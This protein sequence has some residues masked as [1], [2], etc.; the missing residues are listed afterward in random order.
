MFH[1]GVAD[2]FGQRRVDRYGA[3]GRKLDKALGEIDIVGGKRRADLALGDIAIEAS[4]QRLVGD[5]DRILGGGLELRARG[6]A[7]ADHDEG[8]GRAQRGGCQ[9]KQ[10]VAQGLDRELTDHFP[11]IG[12][13]RY[14]WPA[15]CR[16]IPVR[17]A[18]NL[19]LFESW[20]RMPCW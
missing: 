4:R 14:R 2:V 10:R 5:L 19:R 1:R 18:E 7:A 12:T 3:V 9:R 8:R 13:R 16:Q 15:Q 6:D 17:D 20:P 11:S